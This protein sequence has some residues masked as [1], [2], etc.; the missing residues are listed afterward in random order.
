MSGRDRRD[1][2]N[3]NDQR[4]VDTVDTEDTSVS[5]LGRLSEW[6]KDLSRKLA[7]CSSAE[8]P[9]GRL[10][11]LMRL[12]EY[13]CH[14]LPWFVCEVGLLLMSLQVEMQQR[15]LNLF[16]SEYDSCMFSHSFKNKLDRF[17]S[18]Q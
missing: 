2:S 12:L 3:R 16:S 7:L 14:G 10:R 8:S 9:W 6:D 11:P 1:D 5:V 4:S 13:S 18:N 15:L 17:W